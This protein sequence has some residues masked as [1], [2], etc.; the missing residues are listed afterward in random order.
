[1][2]NV[3]VSVLLSL[4][5]SL[6]SVAVAGLPHYEVR[7]DHPS[8]GAKH[9]QQ[10]VPLDAAPSATEAG[11]RVPLDGNACAM[12]ASHREQFRNHRPYFVV[13]ACMAEG[14]ECERVELKCP[15]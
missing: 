6:R 3:A 15:K 2:R 8:H 13:C 11:Q 1:L 4:V 5:G 12:L 9:W 7:C 10:L 14:D